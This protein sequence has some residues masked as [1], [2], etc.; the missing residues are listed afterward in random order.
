MRI[1]TRTGDDGTTGLVGDARVSK[2]DARIAAIGDVDELNAAVGIARVTCR[3]GSADLDLAK[4]QNL[5]FDLGGEL[6]SPDGNRYVVRTLNLRH[7]EELE[8]SMD[9]MNAEL[10]PLKNFILP[11]GSETAARLHLARTICRRAER[12][13]LTLSKEASLRDVTWTYLN[14]LSDWLFLSAR[15]ANRLAGVEDTIWTSEES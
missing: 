7:V 13:V 11:G 2:T 10:P 1:Y 14:R 15:T 3:G 4:I 12:S 9:A 6:A 8:R 5:L